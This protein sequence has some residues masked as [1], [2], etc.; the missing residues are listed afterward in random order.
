MKEVNKMNI[1][2]FFTDILFRNNEQYADRKLKEKLFVF[3]FIRGL[4]V[5]FMVFVHVLGVYASDTV[6]ESAFGYTVDFL[7]SPP[8][9]PVFMFSMG[10]FFIL[11][12][13][14]T[15]VKSG[16]IRGIK[17]LVL[18]SALSFFR[19]DL[20][21]IVNGTATLTEAFQ[22]RTLTAIWE[23]DILQFAGCAYILMSLIKAYLKKPIWWLAIALCTVFISPLVWGIS[24]SNLLLDWL[25]QFLWGTQ[26]DIY[27]PLF[28]WLCYPL[29]G[30]IFGVCLKANAGID[31][32]LKPILKLG[33]VLL[34][35][36][37]I[38]TV[39][40]FDFHIGDY[41]HSGPGSMI[42]ISGFIFVWLWASHMLLNHA[43]TH[44][45]I[46]HVNSWGRNTPSIYFLH[47]VIIMWG[48]LLFGYEKH[49]VLMTVALT[50][51][52]LLVAHRISIWI[53]RKQFTKS[54]I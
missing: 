52:I 10:V 43:P 35:L 27:F 54:T 23:V 13:K 46:N 50:A 40:N 53:K 48:T 36:G 51:V 47:W 18:G 33:L 37:S 8:A 16:I 19:F 29:I 7:G 9:A 22:D 21:Q 2:T 14:S 49:G 30:M 41:Y 6:Q 25:L 24:S 42:W 32:L 34:T 4:A 12:S 11:S 45:I 17:L 1:T 28:G 26:A 20:L 38:I 3:D 15:D 39:T 5:F 31:T 44:P